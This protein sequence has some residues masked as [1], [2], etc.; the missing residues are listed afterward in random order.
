MLLHA[1]AS[2]ITA[3]GVDVLALGIAPTPLV[4]FSIL[5]LAA[6]AGVMVTAS[7]NPVQDNGLKFFGGKGLKIGAADET[8]IEAAILADK[9][10]RGKPKGGFGAVRQVDMEPD[11]LKFLSRSV[12]SSANGKTLKVVLD[13]AYGATAV[14]APKAFENFGSE[15]V[16]ICDKFDGNKINVNCGAT[17]LELLSQAVLRH[18]ANLGLAFDG[19]GD[20]VLAVDEQA[21]TVNGDKIIALFAVRLRR[22]KKQ[23][24]VVMTKMTNMG[25]EQGLKQHG[26]QM[27]RTEVGDVNVLKAMLK[28]GL[29]LG[30]EQSGHIILADKLPAGDGIQAGL[31]LAAM[32]RSSA[33]PLSHLVREFIEYPQL[34]T[35]LNVRD[36]SA[37]LND[38]GFNRQLDRIKSRYLDVRFYLRPSGTENLVRV[39]TESQ[40]ADQCRKGNQA[41]C[42]AFRALDK[43]G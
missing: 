26:I 34:L 8:K 19:D 41:V 4:P 12:K 28:A 32:L 23:G 30:G 39:L 9:P 33:V 29:N 25:I 7:H 6:V 18:K 5:K 38:K 43:K 31:Q 17:N 27:L 40:D 24:S 37:W 21:Q 13:C 35:N 3:A 36:K 22:Y 14:V 2:G 11:Y 1:L 15:V 20:R 42:Q 16:A 10:I